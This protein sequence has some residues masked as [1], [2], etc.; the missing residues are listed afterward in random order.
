MQHIDLAALPKSPYVFKGN[1]YTRYQGNR[2]SANEA[3]ESTARRLEDRGDKVIVIRVLA[4]NLKGKTDEH[5][6]PYLPQ[7]YVFHRSTKQDI[8]HF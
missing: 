4:R 7:L 2:H 5:G 1:E 6:K 3:P 8:A